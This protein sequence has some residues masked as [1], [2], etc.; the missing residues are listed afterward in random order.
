[1]AQGC[2]R[3]QLSS[4][5]PAGNTS[6]LSGVLQF[7]ACRVAPEET[8]E[9]YGSVRQLLPYSAVG[10]IPPSSRNAATQ[11]NFPERSTWLD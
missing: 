2:H 3:D 5:A 10:Y 9:W 1:M 8:F 7:P 6:A 11:L 4:D